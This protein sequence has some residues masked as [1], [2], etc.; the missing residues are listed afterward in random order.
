MQAAFGLG[1]A[2]TS[3]FLVDKNGWSIDG[4]TCSHL[5]HLYCLQRAFL[6]RLAESLVRY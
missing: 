2:L 3:Q 6:D 5:I 1:C 4:E